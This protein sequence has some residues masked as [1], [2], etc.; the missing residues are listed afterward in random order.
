MDAPVP[1]QRKLEKILKE[2]YT[3]YFI[4]QIE[5]RIK[6]IPINNKCVNLTV[7]NTTLFESIN[8]S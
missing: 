3:E 4:S 5:G 2:T 6:H 7:Y 1:W 8:V